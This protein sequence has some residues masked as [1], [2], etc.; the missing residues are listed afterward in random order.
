LLDSKWIASEVPSHED[1]LKAFFFFFFSIMER[2]STI[3]LWMNT[4]LVLLFLRIR[5]FAIE[6][7]DSVSLNVHELLMI[8]DLKLFLISDMLP[9]NLNLPK[10]AS[11]DKGRDLIASHHFR[12]I[13]CKK[14][15]AVSYRRR[16]TVRTVFCLV[17]CRSLICRVLRNL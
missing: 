6:S 3:C 12:F 17:T 13:F 14:R 9:A 5:F 10:S 4:D 15:F 16:Q 7:A 2:R 1:G 8:I 11:V